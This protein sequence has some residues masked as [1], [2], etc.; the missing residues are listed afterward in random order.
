MC[1]FRA[2]R[3]MDIQPYE[4]AGLSRRGELLH[5]TVLTVHAALSNKLQNVCTKQSI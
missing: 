5:F 4:N 3:L 2:V 1:D